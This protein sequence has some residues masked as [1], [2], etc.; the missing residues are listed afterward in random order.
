MSDRSTGCPSLRY[1]SI[2][3]S[4]AAGSVMVATQ[5]QTRTTLQDSESLTVAH[6]TDARLLGRYAREYD[7]AAS[8]RR[9]ILRSNSKS[10]CLSLKST[11]WHMYSKLPVPVTN[12]S[13]ILRSCPRSYAESLQGSR[14]PILSPK[15]SKTSNTSIVNQLHNSRL[16]K[17]R[18]SFSSHVR[19]LTFRKVEDDRLGLLDNMPKSWISK[20]WTHW[21]K[22]SAS[23]IGRRSLEDLTR[24]NHH[25]DPDYVKCSE[26]DTGLLWFGDAKG[27]RSDCTP[28]P[29]TAEQILVLNEPEDEYENQVDAFQISTKAAIDGNSATSE[30]AG[31]VAIMGGTEEQN[32]TVP[33]VTADASSGIRISARY[34]VDTKRE[35]PSQ[36]ADSGSH[37]LCNNPDSGEILKSG[38][39]PTIT[40]LLPWANVEKLEKTYPETFSFMWR[41]ILF[42]IAV[43]IFDIFHLSPSMITHFRSLNT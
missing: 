38:S 2:R 10:L 40:V 36:R 29:A 20:G 25:S 15:S 7:F 28:L 16:N 19:V 5:S 22:P 23:R 24:Y 33:L 12:R 4:A 27:S 3:K 9:S 1:A 13:H 43:I 32:D 6:C 41:F 8:P 31:Q 14:I 39:T 17:K 30:P 21:R 35:I 34:M 18:V 11:H 37:E 42:N 26:I